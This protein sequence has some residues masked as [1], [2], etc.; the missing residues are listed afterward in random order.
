MNRRSI[1]INISK[2]PL[3]CLY[4]DTITWPEIPKHNILPP[5][6][7]NFT[8]REILIII[9]AVVVVLYHN[10]QRTTD[11]LTDCS[12]ISLACHTM[13][14]TMML[15]PIYYTTRG[16]DLLQGKMRDTE[17]FHHKWLQVKYAPDCISGKKIARCKNT[18]TSL[19][20]TTDLNDFSFFV[21]SD[22][23]THN[24]RNVE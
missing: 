9:F 14:H 11:C 18:T 12:I 2:F 5:F 21:L 23:C 19:Y 8:Q 22:V 3:C 6:R 15:I 7:S 20:T 4:S 17:G 1:Y 16:S 10:M 24:M 13:S